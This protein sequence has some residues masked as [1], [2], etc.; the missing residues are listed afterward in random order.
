MSSKNEGFGIAVIEA[1]A[2]GL[3]VIVP[4]IPVMKEITSA[5]ALYFN[6][7]DQNSLFNLIKEILEG[8]QPLN[9]LSLF[10]LNHSQK[11]NRKDY[12][13]K[14]LGIYAQIIE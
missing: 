3:P 4:S 5:N 12:L 8:K 6:L 9:D 2:S 13:E 1:M 7:N 14:L 10:G 11:F